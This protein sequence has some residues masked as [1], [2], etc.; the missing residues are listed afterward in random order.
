MEGS[1]LTLELR[2]V[3]VFAAVAIVGRG[4]RREGGSRAEQS[5]AGQSVA[6]MEPLWRWRYSSVVVGV[7]C[8]AGRWRCDLGDR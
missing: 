6:T 2:A 1:P 4:T 5:R 8:A 3:G 7:V